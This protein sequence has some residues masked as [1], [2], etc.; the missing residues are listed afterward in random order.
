MP[1]PKPDINAARTGARAPIARPALAA[2]LLGTVDFDACL[3]L[4]QRLVYEAGGSRDGQVTLLICEHLPVITVGRQGSRP[5]VRLAPRT[6]ASEGL[7]VRWVNRGGGALVHAPG[8][9]AI[10]PIV[11][12]A[13]HG[14]TVG[15]YLSRLQSGILAALCEL[16]FQGQTHADRFGIWGRTGQIVSLGSA[17]KNWVTYYGAY[18][19]VSPARRILTAVY[20][21]AR[22]RTVMSSLAIERQQNVKMTRVREGLIRHLTE[23]FDCSRY[24]LHTGHVLLSAPPLKNV[25]TA[26]AS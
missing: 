5:D 20:S 14:W 25:T 11:P 16:G 6:L 21:D 2:Y 9:L 22:Q 26:R 1:K 19:N 18:L 13:I 7:S 17:V 12:L 10:Y 23:A 8:Q 3:A 15:E 24:H 4:E